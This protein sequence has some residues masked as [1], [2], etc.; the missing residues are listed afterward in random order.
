VGKSP[1]YRDPDYRAGRVGHRWRETRKRVLERDGYR[2]QIGG[3]RC[4]VIA[5]HVDHIVP[6]MV[7]TSRAQ[8]MTNLRAACA[9]C[10][11]DRR[12]RTT[13]R[14]PSALPW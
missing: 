7:D 13:P 3:P 10:N 14:P 2:C 6:L 9:N 12:Y 1:R 4:T 11:L 5:T 8:D